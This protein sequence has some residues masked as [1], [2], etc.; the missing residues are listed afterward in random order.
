[1]TKPAA[2][3]RSQSVSSATPPS[4]KPVHPFHG[5]PPRAPKR[6]GTAGTLRVMWDTAAAGESRERPIKQNDHG[7][8][9]LRYVV[10]HVDGIGRRQLRVY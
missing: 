6:S 5:Y 8:D 7:L 10:A 1:M 4:T 9:A 3:T 2:N